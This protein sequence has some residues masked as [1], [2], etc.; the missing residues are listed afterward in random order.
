MAHWNKMAFIGG[1]PA[2][3]F[4][5]PVDD[6]GKTRNSSCIADWESFVGWSRASGLFSESELRA[7]ATMAGRE[8]CRAKLAEIHDLREIAHAVLRATAARTDPPRMA[9]KTLEES[10][11]GALARAS[12]TARSSGFEWTVRTDDPHWTIDGLALSV[13]NL[14]RTADLER[15]REC[16][17]CTWLFIDRG[18]GAGRR[19]CDMR[20]CGNR[21]KA[22][23]FRKR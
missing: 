15:L 1:H 4:L 3:D 6:H 17:R 14:L 22:E 9:L 16:G 12:L 10:I 7:L 23:A 19:W 13:E 18:R 20:T 2:L 11:K 8:E 21:A 5:N